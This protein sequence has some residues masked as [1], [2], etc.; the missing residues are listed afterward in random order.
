MII[1]EINQNVINILQFS[2]IRDS[3]N[4]LD[5]SINP[6]EWRSIVSK[7]LK[8]NV[9]FVLKQ[10]ATYYFFNIKDILREYCSE[11][12]YKLSENYLDKTIVDFLISCKLSNISESN[13]MFHVKKWLEKFDSINLHEYTILLP[14]NHYDY[15]GDLTIG[16]IKIIKIN[17]DSLKKYFA[18]DIQTFNSPF[19]IEHLIKDNHT[20]IGA[21]I[22]I[23]AHDYDAAKELAEELLDKFIFSIKLFDYG[24]FISTRKH[25]YDLINYDILTYNKSTKSL[26]LLNHDCYSLVRITPNKEFYKNLENT[27]KKLESFLYS[28]HLT[29][30]QKSILSSLYWYGSIDKLR[31]SNVKKF[32][33]CL[34]GLEKIL[35]KKK[36]SQKGKKFGEHLSIIFSG[37]QKYAEEYKKYYDKRNDLVHDENIQIY[38]EEV[39]TLEIS[40]RYLLLDMIKDSDKYQD[41]ESYYKKYKIDL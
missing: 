17:N 20:N 21:I 36:E 26:S 41:V 12:N 10:K 11:K 2:E 8:H 34:I 18:M 9:M 29:M 39:S 16:N 30:F 40:L 6:D 19:D 37:D 7:S 31:D 5:R 28:E 24:S 32:L 4:I 1:N 22:N 15:N 33:Y 3:T 23:K 27:W 14:I 13:V 35:L 38:D 25:S